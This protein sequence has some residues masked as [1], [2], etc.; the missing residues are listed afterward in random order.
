MIID[1]IVKPNSRRFEV[2]CEL[3]KAGKPLLRVSLTEQAEKNKANL[4]LVRKLS[5]LFGCQVRLLS[6]LKSKRKKLDL[7]LCEADFYQRLNGSASAD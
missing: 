7:E 6:G 4:E 2:K 3:V 1:A 5:K